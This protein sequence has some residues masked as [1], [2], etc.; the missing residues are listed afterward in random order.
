MFVPG[1]SAW[2]LPCCG[3]RALD[4]GQ[5]P[6]R[7]GLEK[8]GRWGANGGAAE[9]QPSQSARGFAGEDPYAHPLLP[10]MNFSHTTP[11]KKCS[12][13][14]SPIRPTGEA[15]RQCVATGTCACPGR[16][17]QFELVWRPSQVAGATSQPLR[18]IHCWKGRTGFVSSTSTRQCNAQARNWCAARA[19]EGKKKPRPAKRGRGF[20]P[21]QQ[22]PRA[23]EG[24]W[25][26]SAIGPS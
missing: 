20:L 11:W 5:L 19:G 23:Q 14:L 18:E 22:I 26:S 16:K 1:V 25:S 10:R 12:P 7:S 4:S 8:L 21:L 9:I 13:L 24:Q 6:L 15:I 3:R 17:S 2:G